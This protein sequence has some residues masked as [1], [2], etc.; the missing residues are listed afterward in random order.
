MIINANN[1][2]PTTQIQIQSQ[3]TND[4]GNRDTSA[5]KILIIR[6]MTTTTTMMIQTTRDVCTAI[7][8]SKTCLGFVLS[9]TAMETAM[10]MAMETATKIPTRGTAGAATSRFGAMIAGGTFAMVATGATNSKRITRYGFVID[11]TPFIAAGVTKWINAT[12]AVRS[13]VALVPP[14]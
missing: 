6:K 1:I 13:F 7:T 12:I 9:T 14:C 11:A 4:Q 10:A 2:V 3:T 8:R 5:K